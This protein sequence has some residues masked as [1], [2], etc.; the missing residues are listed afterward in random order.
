MRGI[1]GGSEERKVAA[2]SLYVEGNVR[3]SRVWD[4]GV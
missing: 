4:G 2:S 1:E 3:A